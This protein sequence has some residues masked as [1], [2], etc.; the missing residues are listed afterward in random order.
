MP[1]QRQVKWAQLR[2]GITVIVAATVLAVLIFLMTGSGGFFTPKLNIYSYFDDAQ[3]LRVGAPVNLQGVPIG[4]VTAINVVNHG[5]TPVRV[6]MKISKKVASEIPTDSTAALTQA[7]VLGETFVNIDRTL[8]KSSQSIT[9]GAILPIHDEP[10]L[11]DVM[12]STQSSLQNVDVLIRRLDRIVSFIESGQGSIG[13]LIYDQ[14]LYNRLNSTLNEVQTMVN[15]ISAGKGSIGKLVNSDELYDKANLAVDNM[16][17][18]IAEIQA[19]N[20]T[21]GKLLKDPS[22]YNNANDAIAKANN[23]MT[24]I[25]QG[26]GAIGKLAKD[27][28]FANKLDNT[29]TKLSELLTELQAGKGTAGMLLK[30]PAVYTNTDQFLVEG[31]KLVQA[32]REDPKKYLTIHV[33]LF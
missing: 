4:N 24:G 27:Q 10:S 11:Q 29:I 8:A 13:K 3:G 20:G 18:I 14:E 7:G 23:L 9:N 33:K 21:V 26:K 25:D 1:S 6:Q 19:G 30:D 15:M 32:M 22:L 16:N 31:R 12:K 2:V 28:E 5:K 17:K